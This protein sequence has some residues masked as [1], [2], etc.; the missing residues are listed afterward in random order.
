MS[1]SF[2]LREDKSVSSKKEVYR[3]HVPEHVATF[4]KKQ[5]QDLAKK[6]KLQVHVRKT[7]RAEKQ[8]ELVFERGPVDLF[9][10]YSATCFAKYAQDSLRLLTEV[11]ASYSIIQ[12]PTSASISRIWLFIYSA[13][14][15][16]SGD[17]RFHLNIRIQELLPTQIRMP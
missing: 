1:C 3:F 9:W 10:L 11:V 14:T 16:T 15:G 4:R 13:D 8:L 2:W 6:K 5:K 17:K 7:A 12:S